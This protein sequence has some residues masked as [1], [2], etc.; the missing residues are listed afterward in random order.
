MCLSFKRCSVKGR[1]SFVARLCRETADA[2]ALADRLVLELQGRRERG[3]VRTQGGG[4]ERHTLTS[5]LCKR[6]TNVNIGSR[7]PI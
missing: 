7:L 5:R 1:I 4:E 3:A 2:V 6:Y